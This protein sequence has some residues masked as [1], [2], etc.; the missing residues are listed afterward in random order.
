MSLEENKSYVT[1]RAFWVLVF[2]VCLLAALICF[3]PA[4]VHQEGLLVSKFW[5]KVDPV[6]LGRA[7]LPGSVSSAGVGPAG[8]L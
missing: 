2:G 6:A 5:E 7:Y 8:T 3:S 4:C 1:I